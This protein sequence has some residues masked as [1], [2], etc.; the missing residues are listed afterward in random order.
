MAQNTPYGH[1]VGT[2]TIYV[3]PLTAGAAE[4]EP[5]VNVSDPTSGTNFVVLGETD[6]DQ[7]IQRTGALTFFSD[8]DHT[9]PRKAV[10]PEEGMT[11][12][13]TLVNLTLEQRA[14]A[15]SLASSAVTSD[16]G[17]PAIKQLPNKRGYYPTVYTL[18]VKGTVHS[19]Y[20]ALPAQFYIP[21]GVFDGEPS[22]TYAKDGRPGLEFI[23]T[24]LEDT[25][26]SSGDEFGHLTAQTA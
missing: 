21:M 11:V 14:Y 13:A 25:A 20:G 15:L 2:A 23:Y 5:D 26:Q 9:G 1:L 16:A 8:N 24:A 4:A 19:P 10:R 7:V 18:L 17:P 12:R 6:G 3:A 22:E